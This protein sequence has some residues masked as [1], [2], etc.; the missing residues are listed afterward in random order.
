MISVTEGDLVVLEGEI[1]RRRY[2][3]LGV[4]ALVKEEHL[5][6]LLRCVVGRGERND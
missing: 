6:S 3:S 4:T 5:C 2:V 1:K